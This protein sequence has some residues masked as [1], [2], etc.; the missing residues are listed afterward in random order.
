MIIGIGT[1]IIEI[2]RIKKAIER[3]NRFI[4]KLFTD[5][6]IE[7][8]KSK[9]YAP[10]VIAGNFAAKE[11][12]SKAV[13]TGFRGFNLKDIEI[14][15]DNLGCPYVI[16]TDKVRRKINANKYKIYISIS[17]SND[18]AIAYSIIEGV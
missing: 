9:N 14:L 7:Y 18:N 5:K 8:F 3:N 10:N 6:E 1:D 15:R 13:G 11:A 12:V 17:H 2:Y 4:N 16:V